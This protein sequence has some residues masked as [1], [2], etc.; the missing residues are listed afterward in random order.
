MYITLF[1]FSSISHVCTVVFITGHTCIFLFFAI[2]VLKKSLSSPLGGC[3]ESSFCLLTW[4]CPAGVWA[5]RRSTFECRLTRVFVEKKVLVVISRFVQVTTDVAQLLG[6]QKVDAIL[7]VA[8]GWA[9]GSCSSKG[10]SSTYLF[11]VTLIISHSF[12]AAIQA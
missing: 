3:C 2:N 4:T 11:A 12:H 5:E 8:G 1:K 7:C 6:E 10:Q 9:G